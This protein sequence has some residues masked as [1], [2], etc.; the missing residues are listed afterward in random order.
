MTFIP[1]DTTSSQASLAPVLFTA[2]IFLSASLLFFVQPLF[3][4]IVL[5]VIGGAPAVWTTA[6]LFFQSV[7][8]AGYVYAHLSTR[9]LP[10]PAQ[11]ATHMVLWALALFF[12]PPALPEAWRLDASGSVAFQT[13][14]LFA[15]G[16][17]APF[18]LLSSNA[19]LIQ[20]WYA[21]SDGPSADDPYFL[22]G[23]SN[24]G[25]L[26]ALLAFPLL[27]EPFFGAGQIATAFSFGFVALGLGLATCGGLIFGRRQVAPATI[28]LSETSTIPPSRMLIWLVLAFVPS[29]LM[30]A[31][32]SKIS[33]DI[34]A[35]PLIWVIP[36]A[37]YLLSFVVTFSGRTPLKGMWLTQAAQLAIVLGLCL[38]VGVAGAHLG[39]MNT[40]VLITCFFLVAVW[41]HRTLYEARPGAGDLTVF[42]VTMSIGGA[43]GGLFNSIVAPVVF[44]D[45]YEGIT[46]LL[47]ALIIAFQHVL[48]LT[49]R[50]LVRGLAL[51]LALGLT[52]AGVAKAL[53]LAPVMLPVLMA[54][55]IGLLLVFAR[56]PFP[57]FAVAA[58]LVAVLPVWLAGADDRRFTDRSFFGLHQVLDRDGARIYTNGTTVH[59]AQSLADYDK[60]RPQP[61]S[62]YHPAG[63]MGQIMSSELG[64]RANWVGIVGLGVGSLACYARDGQYW[65]FYEID[66][67]V[68]QVARDPDQFTFLSSCAPDAP[69]HLGDARV[70]LEDQPNIRFDILVIDAYSSDAVPVHLTTREA[71]ELY[72]NRLNDGG[73][74]VFH[75]SN[76]Y[77]DI[78]LPLARSAEALGVSIWRQFQQHR[79]S[80]DPGY[81]NSDVV[82]LARD[83]AH[84]QPLLAS[85]LW[86]EQSADG[87]TIWTDD[88][89]NPLSIL[90]PGVFR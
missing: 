66:A 83:P 29:S 21:R 25:S 8:I 22:Y 87:G 45:H 19:P 54:G 61:T 76:R 15:L 12:L 58:C 89:A 78:G 3:A 20:S 84:V 40:L 18:A 77:Y 13:L 17:G 64:D 6:M 60:R 72:L 46:T 59:G 50:T 63:P 26:I 7:L 53:L 80:D 39:P 81:R 30:L 86:I 36:L 43:L 68:D 32:T 9:Y 57:S 51:G 88:K 75:I 24:L 14:G 10:V 1:R 31:V 65:H 16:V 85:G 55:G 33:T 42:Y 49:P 74:L 62:Y 82:M 27:A 34:G 69:T 70:V 48:R 11:I 28:T 67:M 44:S 71:M 52:L 5:P 73:V 35:V 38:F 23:A 41:A 79:A 37:L 2:T 47:I 90:K 4:K 56:T